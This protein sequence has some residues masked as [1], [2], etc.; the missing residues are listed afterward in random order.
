M[1][2][3]AG[4]LVSIDASNKPSVSSLVIGFPETGLNEIRTIEQR[5]E[6]SSLIRMRQKIAKSRSKM[7]APS[8]PRDYCV[9]DPPMNCAA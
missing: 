8:F 2:N 4:I 6:W 9:H 3:S 5:Q 7:M 1:S